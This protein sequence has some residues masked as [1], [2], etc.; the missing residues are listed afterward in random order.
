MATLIIGDSA[1]T[2][3]LTFGFAISASAMRTTTR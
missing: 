1:V 2:I 3:S